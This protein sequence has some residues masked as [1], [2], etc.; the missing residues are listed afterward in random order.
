MEPSARKSRLSQVAHLTKRHTAIELI[1]TVG[2]STPAL[3]V[4]ANG[5]RF[6]SDSGSVDQRQH[7]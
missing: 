6:N 4:S 2:T 1:Y 3:R 5:A 7:G